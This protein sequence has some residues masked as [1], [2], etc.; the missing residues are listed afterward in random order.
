MFLKTIHDKQESGR[1][2][3]K[4]ES[5]FFHKDESKFQDCIED[6]KRLVKQVAGFS[7]ETFLSL[8]TNFFTVLMD[9]KT[10]KTGL[11]YFVSALFPCNRAHS[12]GVMYSF[13][14]YDRPLKQATEKVRIEADRKI[15]NIGRD[16]QRQTDM[17]ENASA[18]LADLKAFTKELLA[19]S[20]ILHSVNYERVLITILSV[21]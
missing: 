1:M 20:N 19:V 18:Q 10:A 12:Y 2:Y 5:F 4:Y 14:S 7:R 3:S 21:N 17:F 11:K 9:W 16:L 15:S 6:V 13:C 8:G